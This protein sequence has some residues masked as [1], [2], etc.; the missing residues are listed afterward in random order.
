[1]FQRK[2][3]KCIACLLFLEICLPLSADFGYRDRVEYRNKVKKNQIEHAKKKEL[4]EGITQTGSIAE[5]DSKNTALQF[6]PSE[7][8]TIEIS[9][10][11]TL[12]WKDGKEASLEDLKPG[13]TIKITYYLT[14]TEK[15][16]QF[17]E[18]LPSETTSNHP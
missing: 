10:E 5:L 14:E 16:A 2:W 17:V 6:N 12:V 7:G 13:Q 3:I 4:P 8:P 15:K 1:M 18:I 9:L 11:D